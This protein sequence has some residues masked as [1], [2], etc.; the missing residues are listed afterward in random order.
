MK[1]ANKAAKLLFS[2]GL[3][4]ASAESCTGGMIAAELVGFAGMSAHFAEGYVT[5]SNEAKIKNLGVKESTLNEFG[6]VSKQTAAQMALGVQKRAGADIGIATTGI[7]GPDGGTPEKPVGLV[8]I[9]C[10]FGGKVVVRR[11]VFEGNRYQ[12][13]LSAT[14]QAFL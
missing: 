13:R 11:F 14:K 8:Y 12:V 5:Y 4:I 9:G 3:S 1:Q 2:K 7:A 10:A 6:A